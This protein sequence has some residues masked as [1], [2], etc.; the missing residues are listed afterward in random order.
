MAPLALGLALDIYLVAW[1]I[2]HSIAAGL[3]GAGLV[4]ALTTGLWF[5]LPRIFKD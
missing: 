3:A 5:V 1:L 2:T 4:I